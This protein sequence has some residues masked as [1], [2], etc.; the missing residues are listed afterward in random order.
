MVLEKTLDSPLDCKEIK[1]VNPKGNQ[2]WIFIGRTYAEAE[3]PILWSPNVKRWKDHWKRPWCWG[4]LKARGE[5][6]DR[7]WDGCMA[8][9]VHSWTWIWANSQKLV[10][11]K[12]AWC[13]VVHGVALSKTQ[14]SEWTT[15]A[16]EGK[17]SLDVWASGL[18]IFVNYN[19]L[20]RLHYRFVYQH[21]YKTSQFHQCWKLCHMTFFFSN[22]K[23]YFIEFC[24]SLFIKF[25]KVIDF[26]L[27]FGK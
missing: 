15:T 20:C 25:L 22:A 12:E 8:S 2:L 27:W 6:D 7:G 4:R 16:P 10:K 1:S 5:G 14:L 9:Y 3:A 18:I 17:T 11:D 24:H 19:T 21:S 13:A 23:Y 26:W